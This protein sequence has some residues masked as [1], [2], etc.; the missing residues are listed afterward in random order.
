MRVAFF[1]RNSAGY[2]RLFE[3]AYRELL[4]R[5][6]ELCISLDHPALIRVEAGVQQRELLAAELSEL[7][8]DRVSWTHSPHPEDDREWYEL[9]RRTRLTRD[10]FYFQRPEF[11]ASPWFVQRARGR[12]PGNAVRWSRLPLTTTRPGIAAVTA[13]TNALEKAF[14]PSPAM[15]AHLERLRP[16]VVL[17]S[18][19]LMPGSLHTE[20]VCAA[21]SL[22]LPTAICVASW[23]NLSSKQPIRVRPDVVTVW[24]DTQRDEAVDLHGLP[25]DSIAVTGA[26]VYDHWFDRE[27]SPR[28]EF[29][30]RVGLPDKRPYVI[31]LGGALFPSAITEADFA[32]RWIRALRGSDDP[33][34]AEASVLLRPHPLRA[35]E[36]GAIDF[37][38]E[39]DVV[40]WPGEGRMPIAAD[41]K[42]HFFDS[43][44]HSRAV[45]GLN[46][47]AMIEAGIV[48]RRVL[49]VLA[50]EFAS[51]QTGTLHFRYLT[52]VAG[53]LLRVAADLPEH[54]RDLSDA[55]REAPSAANVNARFLEAFVRPNGLERP[56]APFFVEAVERAAALGHRTPAAV[57]RRSRALRHVLRPVA[58]MAA[59][60]AQRRP[61]ANRRVFA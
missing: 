44:F 15:V 14:P 9:R 36:W 42:A 17:V 13:V 51:S 30:T 50:P 58:R 4:A 32:L 46:T 60:S 47:S 49:S 31:Y 34:L 23:D 22:G 1:H 11:R 12:A 26:Q 28:E 55:L 24:N 19:H 33:V 2:V 20:I 25:T 16:D 43:L 3:N 10:Y 41:A 56:A 48:G 7:H 54:L 6:H 39:G 21:Q 45:V 52:E 37:A 40:V 29:C 38:A 27:P 5:G 35:H 61:A 59:R 57:P 8:G 18:P 53:G